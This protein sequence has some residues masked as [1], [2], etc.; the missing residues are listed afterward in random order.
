MLRFSFMSLKDIISHGLFDFLRQGEIEH[1]SVS[2]V[3]LTKKFI[4]TLSCL[5][6]QV[7]VDTEKNSVENC[8]DDVD[9]DEGEKLA[10]GASSDL[11]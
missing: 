7:K 6:K 5:H 11:D 4:L 1:G 2:V 3:K 9:Y 8:I 10:T